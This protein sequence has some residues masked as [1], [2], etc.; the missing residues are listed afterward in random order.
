MTERVNSLATKHINLAARTTENLKK[1]RERTPTNFH[2]D[3]PHSKNEY[4]P[5]VLEHKAYR[6]C[7]NELLCFH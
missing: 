3:S 6:K 7:V 1:Y 5:L 4:C 2:C